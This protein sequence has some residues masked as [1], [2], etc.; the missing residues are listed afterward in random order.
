MNTITITGN[1]TRDPDVRVFGSGSSLTTFGL[2]D[3][4]ILKNKPEVDGK[5]QTE[6]TFFDCD[7]WGDVG[8]E[9]EKFKKGSRVKVE[10]RIK[11][12]NWEKDG[13]K[14]SKL[15]VVV[16]KIEAEGKDTNN[17][18]AAKASTTAQPRRAAAKQS[19]AAQPAQEIEVPE[20]ASGVPF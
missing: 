19:R 2:A 10:G 14:F 9:V 8:I 5:P 3:N 12:D 18:P 16:L 1:L 15:K 17:A 13:K 11:Q 4:F 6:T 20:S 7:A